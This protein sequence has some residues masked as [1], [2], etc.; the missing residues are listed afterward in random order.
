MSDLIDALAGIESGSALAA[1]RARRQDALRHTQ[2]ALEAL[3][4]PGAHNGLDEAE[5]LAVAL[6]VAT[7]NRDAE[8]AGHYRDRLEGLD[9]GPVMAAEVERFPDGAHGPRQRAVLG[10]V[11]RATLAPR[12]AT[13]DHLALLRAAGLGEPEIVTLSQLVAFVNYQARLLAGLRLLGGRP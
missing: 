11:D 1:L 4:S 7:L 5:R 12:T 6:R 10:H 8:L 13:R 3:L 9:G 2:G